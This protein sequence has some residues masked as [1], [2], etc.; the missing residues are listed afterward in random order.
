MNDVIG[1]PE[2]VVIRG[3]VFWF[4]PLND[5]EEACLESWIR[6]STNNPSLSLNEEAG[7][8]ALDCLAGSLQVLYQSLRRTE[9]NETI[10]SLEKFLEGSEVAAKDIFEAWLR[11]NY[12]TLSA[13]SKPPSSISSKEAEASEADI[14]TFLGKYYKWASPEVVS[15]MTRK[16]KQVY[17]EAIVGKSGDSLTFDTEEEYQAWLLEKNRT[18]GST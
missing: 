17:I 1:A 13:S 3:R 11:I 5:Y 16:Q 14:Y 15:R 12:S 6:W 7:F 18:K 4:S 10:L 2:I 9:P 8:E